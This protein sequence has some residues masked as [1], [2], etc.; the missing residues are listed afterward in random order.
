MLVVV[1]ILVTML[2]P[3]FEQ[4]KS[5]A[6]RAGCVNNLK[7]LYV[8][9]NGYLQDQGHWPQISPTL[10]KGDPQEYARLWQSAFQGYG[11]APKNWICPS[12]QR[13]LRNPDLTLP[14][15]RRVDYIA[16]PFDD[17]PVSPRKF[18][19][20]PWFVER[21]DVHGDGNLVVFTN[22]Q[23]KSLAEITRDA[24]GARPDR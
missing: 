12:V 22:S 9:A 21:G 2:I 8:A 7:S 13:T 6:E 3:A 5:R 14:E 11:I 4:L 15:N 24:G 17:N 10:I 23:I 18:P 16:T 1:G 20:H 19:T